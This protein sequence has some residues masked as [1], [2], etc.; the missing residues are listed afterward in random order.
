MAFLAATGRVVEG[1][2]V[3]EQLFLSDYPGEAAFVGRFAEGLGESAVLVSYNGKS[4]DWPLFR[5]R[6]VMTG[7]REPAVQLHLDLLGTARRLWRPI[8]GSA[9]L[10][11]LEGPVLG[12][13]RT[14]DVPGSEIPAV[15]F[16]YLEKGNDERLPLVMSHNAE[17]V[18]SLAALFGKALRI[19]E[20][21]EGSAKEGEVDLRG[22]G[23]TLVACGRLE[24]GHGALARAA[25]Q[26]D[27]IAA[28]LLARTL[29][30]EGRAAEAGEALAL[31]GEGFEAWTERARVAERLE[32]DLAAAL[33]AA[34]RAAEAAD[35]PP[36]AERALARLRRLELRI[37]GAS[38]G[39][40]GR[41]RS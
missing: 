1:R 7:R 36:R 10:G 4:F 27:E 28:L 40:P 26:G 11:E 8:H 16:S 14:E 30:R 41:T 18:A 24:E 3:I 17:D 21:P 6:C 12:K 25:R 5:N 39:R 38:R 33:A 34:K 35:G 22:L 23:R 29:R 2:L 37:A 19:Y 31:A 9:A 20:A 13:E 32:G 15:Y